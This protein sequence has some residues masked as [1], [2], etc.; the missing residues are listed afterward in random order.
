MLVQFSVENFMSI[1]EKVV[2]SMLASADKEIPENLVE[3]KNEKYLKSA[4]IYGANASGKTNLLKAINAVIIMMRNSNNMQPG[5]KLPISPFKFNEKNINKPTSFEFIMVI[6]NIKYAYGFSADQNRIYEEYLYY[7]PNGRETE[8]FERTEVNKYHYT[9]TERK[10]RDIENKNMENKFFLATATTWN[11]EKTKPVYDFITNGI[12][13]LFDYEPLKA[14]SLEQYYNDKSGEL[15]NFSLHVL[16]EAEMNI[17]GYNISNVEISE[18]QLS[19]IPPE[20]RP[21]ISRSTKNFSVITSHNI[22]DDK[23]NERNISLDLTEESLGTQNMF[24]LNPILLHVLK[25]G[26]ILI[27][28]EL[29]RSLH[30]FLVK[31]IVKLFNS[32][33]HNKNGAQL[34]FNTHDTNLL[35]LNLFRRDQIWF[36]EKDYKKGATDLYPLDDFPV[37]KT[38]NIQ[39]GYLNGRY[40]AIPFIAMGDNLWPEE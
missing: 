14:I 22:I 27:V 28:D 17:N 12:N 35:S 20:L 15:R 24:I 2:F 36:T 7:Y 39:K 13:V 11:Y 30:P 25:K 19:M 5:M 18:E 8:I 9:I 31:Y 37:R 21:F 29:D 10:L 38:E 1:N 6:D 40:G 23:G 26:K 32:K 33:E 34:I 4:V 16:N 3:C